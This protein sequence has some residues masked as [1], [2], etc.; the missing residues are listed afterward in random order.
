MMEEPA[1][2]ALREA[3]WTAVQIGGP[4]LGAM[5]AVGVVISLLQ[6]LTQIQEATVA[7]LPKVAVMGGVLMI[8]GPGMVR[9]MQGWTQHL[10]DQIV[11]LGGLP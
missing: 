9:H 2:L 3:L 4:P 6:A 8:L 5:L 11:A 7:F 1:A 10:F